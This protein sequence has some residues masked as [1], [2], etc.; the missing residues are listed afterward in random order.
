LPVARLEALS[1]AATPTASGEASGGASPLLSPLELQLAVA[2]QTPVHAAS[3][4][5]L[6]LRS[7]PA[8]LSMGGW[9]LGLL[10][11]VCCFA[12]P[13]KEA[14]G[15]V[16]PAPTQERCDDKPQRQLLQ[17]RLDETEA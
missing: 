15:P 17:L 11:D 9:Q 2:L 13:D 16:D 12:D 10:I 14:C 7:S 1:M 6:T 3:R 8:R 5:E 4:T